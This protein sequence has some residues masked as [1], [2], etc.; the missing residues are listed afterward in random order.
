M[1]LTSTVKSK[2]SE[3][4]LQWIH[5]LS[6]HIFQ[7]YILMYRS[8]GTALSPVGC[9]CYILSNTYIT[10]A[11]SVLKHI[12]IL[13]FQR[14]HHRCVSAFLYQDNSNRH[15]ERIKPSRRWMSPAKWEQRVVLKSLWLRSA[16]R[17]DQRTGESPQSLSWVSHTSI[18]ASVSVFKQSCREGG[19][20]YSCLLDEWGVLYTFEDLGLTGHRVSCFPGQHES[21]LISPSMPSPHIPECQGFRKKHLPSKELP[22]LLTGLDTRNV[23]NWPHALG[24]GILSCGALHLLLR[25]HDRVVMQKGRVCVWFWVNCL[26]FLLS[27]NN[28]AKDFCRCNVPEHVPTGYR[29]H[30][31][32]LDEVA[33]SGAPVIRPV[34]ILTV[35][36][37]FQE[38]RFG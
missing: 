17:P 28:P 32:T 35:V 24:S 8:R 7:Q 15:A 33:L 9:A 37:F 19:A 10:Q 38:K 31:K 3:D 12:R 30:S 22:I 5:L 25:L 13:R 29:R 6:L 18:I 2:L 20:W 21:L 26:D 23:L 14:E 1:Y 36:I 4:C 27:T 11:S 34:H 16:T